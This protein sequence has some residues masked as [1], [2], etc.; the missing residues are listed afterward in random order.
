DRGVLHSSFIAIGSVGCC[1]RHSSIPASARMEILDANGFENRLR[2]D[3]AKAAK[4]KLPALLSRTSSLPN[5]ASTFLN[6][7]V[8]SP[9]LDTEAQTATASPPLSAIA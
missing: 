4:R 7:R 9:A 6:S 8:T 5:A 3:S 1:G 2:K